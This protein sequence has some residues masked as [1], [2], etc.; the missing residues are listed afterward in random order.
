MELSSEKAP[1]YR[2]DKLASARQTIVMG[3]R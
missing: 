1:V 3:D 2:P